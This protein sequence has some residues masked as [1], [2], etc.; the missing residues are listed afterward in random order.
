[1]PLLFETAWWSEVEDAIEE[2]NNEAKG[3]QLEILQ[4]QVVQ[5][6]FDYTVRYKVVYLC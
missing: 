3:D 1:M 2:A 5:E 4:F 6:I